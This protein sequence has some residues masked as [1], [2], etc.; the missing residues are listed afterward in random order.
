MLNKNKA[1]S[2]IEL[3][4]V[5]ALLL[6]LTTSILKN[7]RKKPPTIQDAIL[8]INNV[9]QKAFI[10]SMSEKKLFQARFFFNENQELI[11]C[12]YGVL[13]KKED[14]RITP[15]LLTH[16]KILP[17]PIKM[18]NFIVKQ[19]DE[20]ANKTKELWILFFPQGYSQ[21]V[22]FVILKENQEIKVS[23]NPFNGIFELVKDN[24]H[25]KQ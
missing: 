15:S 20:L 25:E 6:G 21:E 24:E 22:S 17:L 19:K 12:G 11:S 3:L 7:F 10:L 13:A 23:I 9:T 14:A 18:K 8:E 1:F 4:L 2:L 16:K 5:V